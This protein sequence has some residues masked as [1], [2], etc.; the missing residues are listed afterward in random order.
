MTA[1]HSPLCCPTASF[2]H[3]GQKGKRVGV[4]DI[5]TSINEALWTMCTAGSPDL[6]SKATPACSF[7]LQMTNYIKLEAR[8]EKK[9]RV[10]ERTTVLYRLW[11]LIVGGSTVQPAVGPLSPVSSCMAHLR[12][13]DENIWLQESRLVCS[14]QRFRGSSCRRAQSVFY[15]SSAHLQHAHQKHLFTFVTPQG[16]LDGVWRSV[17]AVFSCSP[18]NGI[19]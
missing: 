8:A 4:E 5:I 7:V 1:R 12:A 10:Q 9:K 2:G 6:V 17:H 18:L 19:Q 14:H 15:L 3:W 16:V 11:I 13:T